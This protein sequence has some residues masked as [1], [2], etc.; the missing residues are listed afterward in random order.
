[1]SQ[2]RMDDLQSRAVNSSLGEAPDVSNV[3]ARTNRALD[4]NRV[5]HGANERYFDNLSGKTVG[6]IRK[7]LREAFN[8]PGDASALIDGKEVGDDFVLQPSQNLE[9]IKTAGVKGVKGVRSID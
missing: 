2:E 6:S 1:M 5:I 3:L 9:F 8:I 7:S 4:K